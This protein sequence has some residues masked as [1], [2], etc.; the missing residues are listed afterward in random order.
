[1]LCKNKTQR[2]KVNI[3]HSSCLG[4]FSIYFLQSETALHRVQ[5]EAAC[6]KQ[7]GKNS[8]GKLIHSM[9]I[10]ASCYSDYLLH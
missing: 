1:M 8:T 7:T 2:D 9:E 6:T 4:Y 10:Q 5:V 3:S